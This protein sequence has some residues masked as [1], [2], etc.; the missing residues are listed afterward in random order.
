MIHVYRAVFEFGRL[1]GLLAVNV[2]C[3]CAFEQVL[4]FPLVRQGRGDVESLGNVAAGR[5]RTARQ[6]RA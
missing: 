4:A 6:L 5:A 2:K 3:I 1:A